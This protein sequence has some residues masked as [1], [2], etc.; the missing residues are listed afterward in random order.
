MSIESKVNSL[1]GSPVVLEATGHEINFDAD[2]PKG[3]YISWAKT[4]S[5]EGG[6]SYK[7]SSVADANKGLLDDYEKEQ[8]RVL[9]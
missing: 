4:A 7:Y 9:L 2:T 8:Q 1:L 5:D 6:K 3:Y